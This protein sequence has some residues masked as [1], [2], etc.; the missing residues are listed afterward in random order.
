MNRQ[1]ALDLLWEYTKTDSLRKHALAV[2]AAM[3][4]CA[5]KSG[6]DPDVWGIVGLL[7]D[8]D[9]EMYPQFPDHPTKG[10]AILAQH[11]YPEDM[12]E[13]ILG[14]TKQHGRHQQQ[15]AKECFP[16]VRQSHVILFFPI[17]RGC[18]GI[19]LLLFHCYLQGHRLRWLQFIQQ[20]H[21]LVIVR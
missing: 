19:Y 4:A 2:E 8:F 16:H 15:D 9:Y 1:D 14:H 18:R 6:G 3:R 13:A 17:I 21:S 11:G 20:E 7:H 5:A 12:R 10:S